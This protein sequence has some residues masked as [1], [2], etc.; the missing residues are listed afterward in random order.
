MLQGL[1]G[2]WVGVISIVQCVR[3]QAQTGLVIA[4]CEAA[5]FLF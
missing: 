5:Y 3:I 2:G 4:V 1:V